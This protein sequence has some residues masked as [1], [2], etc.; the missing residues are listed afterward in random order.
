[1]YAAQ[2]STVWRTSL[3]GGSC[4]CVCLP[5]GN[6]ASE[7]AAAWAERPL[8]VVVI[9]PVPHLLHW[10]LCRNSTDSHARFG[11]DGVMDNA[12]HTRGCN[13]FYSS[14]EDLPVWGVQGR[15]SKWVCNGWRVQEKWPVWGLKNFFNCGKSVISEWEF[16]PVCSRWLGL[17]F[18][19]SPKEG[20]PGTYK[21]AHNLRR[22]GREKCIA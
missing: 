8:M 13:R 21:L 22:R 9:V 20:G 5:S 15:S 3:P 12:T 6:K 2:C 11:L 16:L 10:T 14:A 17:N 18:P 4:Q 19:A 1:M 7:Q